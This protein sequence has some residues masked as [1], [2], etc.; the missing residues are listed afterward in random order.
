M[1]PSIDTST[2]NLPAIRRLKTYHLPPT[3]RLGGYGSA[4]Y[5]DAPGFPSYMVQGVYNKFGG[6]PMG[7]PGHVL[8]VENTLYVM[9]PLRREVGSWDDH[10]AAYRK[11]L[12]SLWIPLPLEHERV[13]L[14]MAHVYQHF[15]HCYRD[16]ERLEHDKPGTL[17]FPLPDY[18]LKQPKV[19]SIP[20]TS[21][22]EEIAQI[23]DS[24]RLENELA[25]ALNTIEHTR[26]VRIA[27]PENHQAVLSIRE[28]YPEHEPNLG[29]IICPPRLPQADWWET[30]AE[31]PT[32]ETCT[33]RNSLQGRGLGEWSH[34]K[35]PGHHCHFCGHTNPT[36]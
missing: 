4:C 26:A 3:Y 36:N 14:W 18:A 27:I 16:S 23:R 25:R 2:L 13:Q 10:W 28:F 24:Q 31:C 17:V 11:L 32:P 22:D 34:P 5:L 29:W 30:S 12:H 6:T 7:A 1:H 33:P 8:N 20:A 35:D 15:S 21:T 9:E 19:L